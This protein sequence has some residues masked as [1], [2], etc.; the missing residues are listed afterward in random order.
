MG[1][2]ELVVY[3]FAILYFTIIF[4]FFIGIVF[5]ENKKTKNINNI[6][7]IIAARNEEKHLPSL[8]ESL[9]SQNFPKENYE[10]IVIDDRSEDKTAE[11][12]NEYKH[13]NSNITLL[14]IKNESKNL[15]GKKGAVD[16]GIRAAKNDILAFTDA[17]CVPTQNWLLQIS[18]HF[19]EDTDIVAG[20]SFIN[21]KNRF[22]QFLK[23]LERSSI[24]A[25]VAGSFGWNW[26]IT[27]TA[28]NMAY[29]KELFYKV[30]G[31][32]DIGTVR[33]GDDD[34]MIQKMGKF[35]HRMKFMFHP[36]SVINTGR[37]STTSS[38]MNQETRRG[39]KWRYYPTSVKIM[40]L[41]IFVYY[42]IFIGCFLGFL[43]GKLSTILLI[44]IIILKIIP[45]FLLITLFLSRIKRLRLM[46]VF[47]IA[48]LIYIPYF[49]FFGLKG[50]FG[51]FKWKE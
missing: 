5:L 9:I 18:N 28:G 30:G 21:Y 7:I 12:V 39:S 23:N 6:S 17:D 42:L 45:E 46:W 26:G 25:I 3:T 24:F 38:Q 2:M 14:Q 10:I 49:I 8:L 27:I 33:S 31:F 22:F 1:I 20:Y 47:P 34:L 37:D 4:S 16:K 50:T 36:D 35:A 19:T 11:I 44:I 13:K 40:T 48:E 29:R 51:K 15:I 32:G 41:F 43:F